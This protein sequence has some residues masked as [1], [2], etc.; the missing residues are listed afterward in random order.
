MKGIDVSRWQEGID[1]NA[2]RHAGYEFV[3]L[4]AGGSD[5]GFYTDRCF[6]SFYDQALAA[7]LHVGAYYF[8]GPEFTSAGDGRADAKRFIQI[9]GN[10]LFDMPV[11]VDIECTRPDDKDGVTDAAIA[12][13]DTMEAAGYFA[14]IYASEYSG[15]R[16]RLD[17]DCLTLYTWWVAAWGNTEPGI[18][19]GIWQYNNRGCVGG[20]TVDEDEAVE[21]FPAI[22]TAGGYNNYGVRL[23]IAERLYIIQ[24]EIS[25]LIK[26]VE[27]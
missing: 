1:F 26:Y 15:F 24:D 5:D 19:C 7:G 20:V 2:V 18:P 11:Y 25:T 10:R 3:I 14:G 12:F 8:V 9:L 13:C 22:I 27:R 17:A 16:D 6:E 21:D 23:S 4:K